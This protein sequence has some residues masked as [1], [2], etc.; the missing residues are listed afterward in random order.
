MTENIF[1]I[2]FP[3]LMIFAA[4]SDLLT[5]TIP[6]S[7]P[8]ALILGYVA[9]ALYFQFSF[10]QIAQDFL[11][12]LVVLGVCIAFFSLNLLGGGDAKLATAT[13]FWLGW[14]NLLSF[15]FLAS[16]VGFALTVII[17]Y[18]RFNPLPPYLRAV[19]FLARLADKTSGVP[20]GV[21]LAMGGLFVYPQ[22]EIWSYISA[23]R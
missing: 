23:L 3:T 4:I 19:K 13:A 8:A 7:V 12:G 21:A 10:E 2:I 22:T 9:V 6:N 14:E 15:G 1:L 18:M 11:C 16:L 17:V 20:Y 5:F